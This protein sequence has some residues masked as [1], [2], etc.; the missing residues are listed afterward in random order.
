MSYTT[1][2]STS[3][4]SDYIAGTYASGQTPNYPPELDISDMS[5]SRTSA[6]ASN[7]ARPLMAYSTSFTSDWKKD[8]T[9]THRH[10]QERG[11]WSTKG[12]AG[13]TR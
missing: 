11:S 1:T 12:N 2:S 10:Y 9:S 7:T 6:S 5:S 4:S 3:M 8:Y 13:S